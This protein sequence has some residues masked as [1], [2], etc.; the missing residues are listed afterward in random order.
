M[1]LVSIF[2]VGVGVACSSNPR[3]IALGDPSIQGITFTVDTT[4]ELT[5]Q[6]P[7]PVRPLGIR[8]SWAGTRG[9][10]DVLSRPVRPVVKLGDVTVGPSLAMPGDYYLFDSTGF[11]LVR[12]ATKQYSILQL[13]DAAFNYDGRRDGW[14]AFFAF[15][16]TRVDTI[17]ADAAAT[18]EHGEHPIYWHV[19]VAKDSVCTVGG[20]SIEELARGRTIIADAPVAELI[21]ARWFGPAQALGQI[22]GGVSRLVDKPI[23]VTTVSPVT[24]IH[25][26]RD[27]RP[28]SVSRAS[29]T[30]PPDFVEAPWPGFPSSSVSRG[31]D[32]GAKWRAFA[33]SR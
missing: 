24:G 28:T 20:C 32:R 13:S 25:R 4:P 33:G 6:G 31:V 27:L 18:A 29:L 26:I 9:R 11:V 30:V 8:V 7:G 2:L 10:I 5:P 22:A 16:P 19:D 1:R 17:A 12:P 15:A 23:R 3:P 14:P 21:V